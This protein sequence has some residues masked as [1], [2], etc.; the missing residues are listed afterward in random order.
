M[1]HST[2]IF[3]INSEDSKVKIL[4]AMKKRG[5]GMG[6]WNGVGGKVG[7]GES[8]LNAAKR[9][10]MEE[11]NVGAKTLEKVAEIY[12]D[13]LGHPEWSQTVTAYICKSWEGEPKESEE[14]NP[15]WFSLDEIPYDQMW[16][17]DKYWLPIV[18]EGKKVKGN[19]VFGKENE[20]LD[21]N[22]EEVVDDQ[23]QN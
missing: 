15:K 1:K 17:D 21:Y 7:E 23:F 12:F 9:E 3:L 18:L 5:F 13:D 14:M 11:I 10:C 20:I 8:I 16:I 4:L 19:F 2:L 6:L 22:I